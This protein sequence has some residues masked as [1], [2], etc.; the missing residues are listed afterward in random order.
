LF[1]FS[2]LRKKNGLV[3]GYIILYAVN[4]VQKGEKMKNTPK[5]LIVLFILFI[6]THL[7]AERIVVWNLSPQ[8]GVNEKT[9]MNKID[10]D[11]K[12]RVGTYYAFCVR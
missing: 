1:S 4:F 6:S 8:S 10:T 5:M 11:E 7:F 9:C 3:P 2:S 12:T